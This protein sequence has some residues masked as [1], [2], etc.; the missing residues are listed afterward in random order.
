MQARRSCLGIGAALLAGAALATPAVAQCT[1]LRNNADLAISVPM[2]TFD[3][4]TYIDF[5]N[6]AIVYQQ[7]V[8]LSVQAPGNR[9]WT[10]CVSSDVPDLGT[11][12]GFTK[13]LADLQWQAGSGPWTPVSLVPQPLTTE[14]GDR[15]IQVRVRMMLTWGADPPG[16]FGTMV[17]F[18]VAG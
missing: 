13:P 10:V 8:T 15:T 3:T 11:V 18:T 5:D 17:N 4:P 1:P 7:T 16:S 6:G 14:R 9:P 12:D 2:L